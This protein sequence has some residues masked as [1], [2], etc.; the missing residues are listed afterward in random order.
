MPIRPV[1]PCPVRGGCGPR[2]LRFSGAGKPPIFPPFVY[3]VF[4]GFS[5]VS[6]VR[7]LVLHTDLRGLHI[8]VA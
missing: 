8:G 2:S 1:P 5:T 7:I 6:E 4:A 3:L